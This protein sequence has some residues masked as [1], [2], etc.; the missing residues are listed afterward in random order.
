MSPVVGGGA[1]GS[2]PKGGRTKSD[3]IDDALAQVQLPP[4]SASWF[5][6]LEPVERRG[7]F[8][9]HDFS[10]DYS[11]LER[12]STA[13]RGFGR[14]AIGRS[15]AEAFLARLSTRRRRGTFTMGVRGWRVCPTPASP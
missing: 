1:R 8:P 12:H 13:L 15:R 14:D 9:A 7:V 4:L 5:V 2:G 3:M 10:N 11:G 6:M